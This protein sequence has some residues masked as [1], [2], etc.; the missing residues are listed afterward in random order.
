M[1]VKSISKAIAGGLATGLAFAIPIVD[2]GLK[3]SE[4]LGIAAAFLAGLGIVYAAPK[5]Q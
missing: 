5:N 4:G 3:W 2:D 1:N